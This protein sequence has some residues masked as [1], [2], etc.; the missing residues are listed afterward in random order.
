MTIEKQTTVLEDGN[1]Q[2]LFSLVDIL[3]HPDLKEPDQG[4]KLSIRVLRNTPYCQDKFN[5]PS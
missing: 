2:E 1:G 3:M 5:R 4:Q